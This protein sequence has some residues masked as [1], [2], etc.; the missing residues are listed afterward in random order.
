VGGILCDYSVTQCERMA[1]DGALP[2]RTRDTQR[3]SA[4]LTIDTDQALRDHEREQLAKLIPHLNR[5]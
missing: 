3:S 1:M 4:A 2:S 5:L